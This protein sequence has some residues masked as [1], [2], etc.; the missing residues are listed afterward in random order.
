M[1]FSYF[2]FRKKSGYATFSLA[3]LIFMISVASG[4]SKSM[5]DFSTCRIITSKKLSKLEKKAVTIFQEEIRKRSG[6]FLPVSQKFSTENR[7]L[8]FIGKPDAAGKIADQFPQVFRKVSNPGKE[9]YHLLLETAP[10][11][12]IFVLGSDARGVLYGV[13]KLLRK[14]EMRSG[15]ILAPENLNIST[16]PR[17]PIRGHQLGY[18]PKTNAYDAWDAAQFDRYIR[19][20]ALFGANSIEIMPPRT[21]DDRSSPHM[22]LPA[23]EMMIRQAEI[24]D[25]YGLDVWIWYPNMGKNYS[26][27]DS[28]KKELQERNK[29]FRKLKRV[30]VVF[31]PGGDPGDLH[32]T[33][34]FT[35]LKE[36]AGVLNK[37]HPQAKIWVSPQA[38]RP[39]KEWLDAFYANVN[40][41]YPWFGGVVFGPWV[42]TTLP[43]MR[44]LVD[45]AIPIRRYPD[46]T[47]SISSQYPVKDWDLAFAMTLGR[48]C[49]NPRPVAEKTIHNALD[50]Y[51]NGSLSYSE[52]I[53]DDVNKFVW[54]DQDW[55]PEIPVIETLR[56]Y[57]RLF[58]SPDYTD[59]IAR[60]I[61]ALEENWKG[62]LLSNRKVNRTL[63]Q[64]RQLEQT[65]PTTVKENYRFQMNLLR[66][67]YDAY[68][69]QR[70]I[71]ETDLEEQ[72][73]ATLRQSA[74]LGSE[75]AI[76]QAETLLTDSRR[77][78]VSQDY[79]RKCWELAN[80]LFKKIGSQ[81]SVT[82]HHAKHGRGDFMDYINAPLNEAVF[83]LS[84]LADI[85]KLPGEQQ[86]LAEIKALLN[87]TNPGP[88]GFYDN[89]G[90]PASKERLADYPAW[91]EDPGSLKSPRVSFG[92][93]LTGEE[94]VHTV[95]ARG[96]EGRPTPLAWMNQIT[97]LY[98]TPLT[99]V[100]RD[101]DP[102]VG[103][104]V[105]VAYTGRFRSKLKLVADGQFL[106]HDLMK[107]GRKP[108]WE[109]PIPRKATADG[110]LQLTWTCGEGERGS[111]VA[112]VWL[113][114]KGN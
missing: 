62:S 54:S 15:Q 109:F 45:P 48:E 5:L 66:A 88:G 49:Y 27:P 59:E 60:G 94:W 28:I 25:S 70:L 65:A 100:Y 55:D 84:R 104:V 57:S 96:F 78:P 52:G 103:Y 46:I 11:L 106:I 14:M 38:F 2:F 23:M 87:R 77:H 97:T 90:D 26:N 44:K 114:R 36:V 42:K 93:G 69:R 63:L 43:E 29:I 80:S 22:K 102:T 99:L 72:A 83:L 35:W 73:L 12:V 13:G 19:E 53:N 16:A 67:Y 1:V 31:V 76:G 58:I 6:I 86:K 105:K 30:D 74:D 82:A 91:G 4:K 75:A 21:D 79:Y 111:Q 37:Y 32:P 101:L 110:T 34:L 33:I 56:D 3:I 51:A 41:K 47:H 7:P 24:I 10:R 39:V 17:Y 107:T 8:I 68:I 113:M 98:Q 20:L 64:W 61:L 40:R 71:H 9:G 92:V 18:R 108:I 81:T 95:Q 50:Q 112:E 85:R 89:P